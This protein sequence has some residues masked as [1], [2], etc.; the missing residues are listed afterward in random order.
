MTKAQTVAD[1]RDCAGSGEPVTL[2][3]TPSSLD[4]MLML[5]HDRSP[6]PSSAHNSSAYDPSDHTPPTTRCD[7]GTNRTESDLSATA[8]V[9]CPEAAENASIKRDLPAAQTLCDESPPPDKLNSNLLE[10]FDTRTLDEL[11]AGSYDLRHPDNTTIC[12]DNAAGDGSGIFDTP[13]AV[14]ASQL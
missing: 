6:S 9:R 4:A 5:T 7:D 2:T 11:A 8:T 3:V 14:H 13:V 12:E 1:L 10:Q